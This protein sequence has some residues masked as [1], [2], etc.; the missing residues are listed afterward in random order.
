VD[1]AELA[2]VAAG[3][4]SVALT[5]PQGPTLRAIVVAMSFV[6][7]VALFAFT[8]RWFRDKRVGVRE[9]RESLVLSYLSALDRTSL[10][11]A[12]RL[13]VPSDHHP[14]MLRRE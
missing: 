3:L 11:P 5:I 7:V 10:N 2:G 8:I 14:A 6:G 9:I 12:A 1:I 4:L 13:P